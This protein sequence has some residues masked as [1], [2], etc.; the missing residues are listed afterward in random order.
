MKKLKSRVGAKLFKKQVSGLARAEGVGTMIST[1]EREGIR[2]FSGSGRR[3]FLL[4]A[5]SVSF[6][7][8]GSSGK[9]EL[10]APWGYSGAA[11][12]LHRAAEGPEFYSH[13]YRV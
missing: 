13:Q 1:F 2:C 8:S 12:A 10:L 11:A 6:A 3:C 7:L 5:A 9:A 4:R